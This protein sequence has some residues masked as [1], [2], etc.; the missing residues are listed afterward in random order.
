MPVLDQSRC[1]SKHIF[2]TSMIFFII[3]FVTCFQGLLD[4]LRESYARVG[5]PEPPDL[6]EVATGYACDGCY[7]PMFAGRSEFKFAYVIMPKVGT[8]LLCDAWTPDRSQHCHVSQAVTYT[9]NIGMNHAQAGS[10]FL[11]GVNE[12][13]RTDPP[14]EIR[15]FDK[16]KVCVVW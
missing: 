13:Y 16:F 4:S 1:M 14:E 6:Y 10:L 8:I 15:T 7:E 11:A 12:S 9:L 5:I 2:K 3:F